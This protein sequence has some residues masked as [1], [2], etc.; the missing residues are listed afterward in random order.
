MQTIEI[1]QKSTQQSTTE[2]GFEAIVTIAGSTFEV[3][4]RDPFS[5]AEEREMEWYFEQWIKFPFTDTTIAG[6]AAEKVRWYGEALFEQVFA[7]RAYGAYQKVNESLG[8]L[9]IVVKGDPAFQALHWE[10]MWDR[11]F[12]RPLAIDCVMVRERKVAGMVSAARIQPSAMLNLLIVTARPNEENDVGYRTISRPM[13]E[14]IA[15]AKLRVNVEI[16]RPGTFEAFVRHLEGKPEGFYHVVHFDLHGGLMTY[17]Q[18]QAYQRSAGSY[19]FQRSYGLG[20]LAA[21][22]GVRAFLFFE[23]EEKGLA[24]PVTAREMAER[25]QGRGIPVCILN[26][27]QSGKQTSPLAPLP[28][29]EGNMKVDE[30]ETSLG[31]RLMDAGMQMVVAMG[32][33]VTVDAAKVLMERVYGSLFAGGADDGGA[34]IGPQGAF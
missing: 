24:V 22:E 20:D 29:G 16:V 6:R 10:A 9:E 23:G 28:E 27:C 13:V 30:R 21:Y 15:N 31:A 2:Q 1:Q 7:G 12:A 25:L 34:A 17:G 18:F 19:T 11:D 33:S 14:A 5:L 3:Q 8:E 4:V 26:A 32:Y